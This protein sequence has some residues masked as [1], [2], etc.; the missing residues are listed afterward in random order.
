MDFQER[1]EKA[2][3]RGQQAGTDRA[4]AEAERALTEKE[5]QRLHSQYRLALSER[6]E[7]CLEQMADR[8]PGF[9]FETIVDERGWGAAISREDIHI[10]A[11][12]SG[13]SFSRLEMVI[14]PISAY[15]VLE[16]AAKATVGNRELFRRTHYQRLAEVD[17]TSFDELIDLWVLEC[18]ER[19]AAESRR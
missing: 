7:R 19:Y 10:K 16:L 3:E 13:T 11:G 5:L 12:R 2:I 14:R 9:R 6:I 17:P 15:F 18:A 8:F 1:L 4:R